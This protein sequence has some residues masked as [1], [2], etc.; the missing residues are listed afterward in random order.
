MCVLGLFYKVIKFLCVSK[1][2]HLR[3]SF[4]C[5]RIMTSVIALS[6]KCLRVLM[7]VS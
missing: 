4:Q 7:Q 3:I 1:G 6:Y 5:L 2:Q